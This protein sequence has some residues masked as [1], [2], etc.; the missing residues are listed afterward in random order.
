MNLKINTRKIKGFPVFEIKGEITKENLSKIANKLENIKKKNV[1]AVI[2]D[3]SN[4]NFIDSHG[5]GVFV[6]FWHEMAK[7][8]KEL[9]FFRPLGFV[10][11][12]L[13][14][15]SLSRIFRIIDSEEEL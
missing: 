9:I 11:Q 2:F 7:Q 6:Y 3:M 5:L 14:E 4:T 13:A 1:N 15:T 10:K 8:K 12:L